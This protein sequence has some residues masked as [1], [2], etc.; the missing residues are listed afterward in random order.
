MKLLKFFSSIG[1]NFFCQVSQLLERIFSHVHRGQGSFGYDWV[2]KEKRESKPFKQNEDWCVLRYYCNRLAH[3]LPRY[4]SY[5]KK[6]LGLPA[7]YT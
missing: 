4:A 6:C 7:R 3:E 5:T 1:A 2:L